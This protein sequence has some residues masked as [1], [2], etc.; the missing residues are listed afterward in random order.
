MSAPCDC[1]VKRLAVYE[2]GYLDND[3]PYRWKNTILCEHCLAH[4]ARDILTTQSGEGP[5]Y[6]IAL[7]LYRV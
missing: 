4:I 3:E 1:C 7:S 2:I 5:L 6:Q